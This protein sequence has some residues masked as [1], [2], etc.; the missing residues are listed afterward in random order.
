M[1]PPVLGSLNKIVEESVPRF[2]D[3]TLE[4]GILLLINHLYK[5]TSVVAPVKKLE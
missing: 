2:F 5:K 4:T 1:L 3:E